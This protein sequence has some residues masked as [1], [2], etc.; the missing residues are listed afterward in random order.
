MEMAHSHW[1]HSQTHPVFWPRTGWDKCISHLTSSVSLTNGGK[2]PQL[3]H[4]PVI[5][6]LEEEQ[7]DTGSLQEAEVRGSG[8]DIV[9]LG[10]PSPRARAPEDMEESFPWASPE[11]LPGVFTVRK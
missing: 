7:Q 1:A 3:Q 5:R 10:Q 8:L 4:F 11:R 9:E 6:K 2:K